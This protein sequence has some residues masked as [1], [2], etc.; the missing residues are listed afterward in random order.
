MSKLKELERKWFDYKIKKIISPALKV[1]SLYLLLAGSYYIYTNK[2][3]MLMSLLPLN[4][5]TNVLGVS[6][7]V[8]NSMFQKELPVE[9]KLLIEENI[10]QKEESIEEPK[11]V[12]KIVLSPIIPVIDMEKEESISDIK[13]S[14]PL[15]RAKS[16][17][18]K[19][20]V[21]AKRNDYL[22]VKELAVITRT[23]K[24]YEA[25][26]RK[27]KKMNFTSTSTNYLETMK[28]KFFKSN[29]PRDAL[30]LAKTYYKKARYAESEK[31]A[32]SANKLD[33]SLE[34]SWLFFAK[35]KAKLGKKKEALKILVSYYKKS[36]SVK[37]KRL[38]GQ[39]KTGRL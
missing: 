1:S 38:I 18:V 36:H 15:Q 26:P 4:T 24:K 13:H 21:R 9:K 31:W 28:A 30:L 39:I 19:N 16:V 12:E 14:K 3:D 23:Q 29:S 27:T 32:L 8:N 25:V 35:S 6:I 10:P 20:T 22:T 2:S 33:N 5:K 37:A 17:K 34:D 11:V 7:E